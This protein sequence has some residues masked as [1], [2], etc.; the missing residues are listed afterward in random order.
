MYLGG[1]DQNSQSDNDT[2]TSKTD[3]GEQRTI[4]RLPSLVTVFL[5]TLCQQHPITM[6][7]TASMNTTITAMEEHHLLL[8]SHCH[9]GLLSPLD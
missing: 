9:R 5:T 4:D 1:L 2:E 3:R 6:T 7:A 8:Q